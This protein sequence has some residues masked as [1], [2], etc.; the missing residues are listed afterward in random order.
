MIIIKCEQNSDE[1][2]KLKLG[3]P[4]SSNASKIITND[5][6]VSKQR[7]GY[8]YELAAEIV[9]G[10]R[11]ES[12]KNANIQMGQDREEE[13]RN[14]YEF[15]HNVKVNQ[16]GLIYKDKTKSVLCSPDGIVNGKYGLELKNVIPKTQVKYLL[17]GYIPS[18]YK[19]QIQFSLY[20]TGFQ[21]WDFMSYSPNLRPLIIKVKRDESFIVALHEHL[22]L[23]CAELKGI[24]KKIQ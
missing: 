16:V 9:T 15:M 3:K 11:E 12:Y 13:S 8:L 23:F 24:V 22:L 10:Q 17:N 5:G 7:T 1:W 21:R 2:F 6:K 14:I 19:S 20:I 18:E 4:S